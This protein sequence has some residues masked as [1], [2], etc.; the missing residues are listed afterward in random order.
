MTVILKPG[1]LGLDDWRHLAYHLA[2]DIVHTVV[3]EGRVVRSR[4]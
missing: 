1:K 2:G 3:R 4:A